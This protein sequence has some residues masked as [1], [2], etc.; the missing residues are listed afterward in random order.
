MAKLGGVPTLA[1]IELRT[2]NFYFAFQVVQ[3]FLVITLASAAS[4]VV[5][6][7]IEHP[8]SA[9]NLLATHLPYASNF[10]ID[11]MILQ[12]LSF[13]AGA[14]LQIVGL[15][16]GKILGYVLDTTPRKIYKRWSN[17]AGLSWGTIIPP[18]SLLAV[19]GE[20]LLRWVVRS[21]GLF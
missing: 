21:V 17:L 13:S 15:L 11:Y 16:V 7:I 20:C 4:S 19:I 1:A 14:L 5:T 8:T 3:V 12:G 2:Q 10:Y 9:A 6:Q 18:I